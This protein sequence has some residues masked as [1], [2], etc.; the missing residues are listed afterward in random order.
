M[1]SPFA[2]SR[3][4]RAQ[5]DPIAD[6]VDM[7]LK[8][9]A[10]M[11][12]DS[13]R[14]A[15]S[16]RRRAMAA[17]LA[18]LNA[19]LK[20]RDKAEA[21]TVRGPGGQVLRPESTAAKRVLT[22]DT[23]GEQ[24]VQTSTGELEPAAQNAPL[25]RRNGRLVRERA[26]MRPVDAGVDPATR[27]RQAVEENL[28]L[29]EESAQIAQTALDQQESQAELAAQESGLDASLAKTRAAQARKANPDAYGALPED[30]D[31]LAAEERA[32]AARKAAI[33]TKRQTMG[34]KA[35]YGAFENFVKRRKAAVSQIDVSDGRLPDDYLK[36]FGATKIPDQNTPDG[37]KERLGQAKKAE[38]GTGAAVPGS[39]QVVTPAENQAQLELSEF[40]A[41]GQEIAS[42]YD[43]DDQT[44]QAKLQDLDGQIEQGNA[45]LTQGS[46]DVES[47]AAQARTAFEALLLENQQA[48]QANPDAQHLTVTVG[49]RKE[50]W[51]P[52]LYRRREKLVADAKK[53]DGDLQ[54]MQGELEAESGRLQQVVDMRNTA[55]SVLNDRV[56]KAK[57]EQAAAVKAEADR[58][59]SMPHLAE[60]ADDLE[61][62]DRDVETR[63]AKV[64]E[65]FPEGGEGARKAVLEEARVSRELLAKNI[66]ETDRAHQKKVGSAYA[67]VRDSLPGVNFNFY[68]RESQDKEKAF[69]EYKEGGKALDEQVDTAI[70]KAAQDSGVPE[71][72][73][74]KAFEREREYDWTGSPESETSRVLSTGKIAVKPELALDKKAY[75][76]AIADA[77]ATA[78][79]K[80]EAYKTMQADRMKVAAAV[81]PL[82]ASDEEGFSEK[83]AKFFGAYPVMGPLNAALIA[84]DRGFTAWQEDH[85]SDKPQAE[86][87]LEYFDTQSNGAA[88]ARHM[89][90]AIKNSLTSLSKSAAGAGA[91]VTDANWLHGLMQEASQVEK[92][93]SEYRQR[94]GVD[95]NMPKALG[96][97][98]G[99]AYGTLLQSAP[100]IVGG[101]INPAA[102]AILAGAQSG[103][104]TYADAY[105]AYK[106]Q[107]LD[108]DSARRAARAPAALSAASTGFLTALGG[109]TGAEGLSRVLNNT[110]QRN[111][112]HA[113]LRDRLKTVFKETALGTLKGASR[114]AFFEEMPD[115]MIQ[116]MIQQMSYNTNLTV[117]EYVEQAAKAAV[118]GFFMGGPFSAMTEGTESSRRNRV[119]EQPA[120][121]SLTPEQWAG[122]LESINTFAPQGMDPADVE[123]SQ[124]AAEALLYIGRGQAADLPDATL[125]T[126]G[127]Q[128]NAKGE[129]ENIKG[130]KFPQVKIEN[131]NPIIADQSTEWLKQYMPG[132][133]STLSMDEMGARR[134]FN[135]PVA[136]QAQNATQSPP[137]LTP[138]PAQQTGAQPAATPAPATS[139]STSGSGEITVPQVGDTVQHGGRARKVQSVLPAIGPG[140]AEAQVIFED[141]PGKLYGASTL[142]SGAAPAVE[143]E[144]VW[145]F[146]DPVGTTHILPKS[147]ASSPVEAAQQFTATTGLEVQP[148][149]VVRPVLTATPE[150]ART[151]TTSA[152]VRTAFRALADDA[153]AKGQK[154]AVAGAI[155]LAGSLTEKYARQYAGV[156]SNVRVSEDVP[157]A[158]AY[159]G[160]ILHINPTI[161]SGL[162]KANIRN[163]EAVVR[164][165]I[166]EEVVHHLIGQTVT[167][168]QLAK[169]WTDLPPALRTVSRNAY[170]AA[171][172]SKL[173]KE[174]G[175][176]PT[177]A[178]IDQAIAG[179]EGDDDANRGEEF[180]RQLLQKE[181][182]NEVTEL[183]RLRPSLAEQIQAV[184]LQ[185][186]EA[187]NNVLAK[188]TNTQT[189]A[190]IEAY[191]DAAIDLAEQLGVVA[192]G[193]VP[194]PAKAET[195]TKPLSVANQPNAPP[196][197]APSTVDE[198]AHQAAASPNNDLKPPTP[199]QI[200]ADNYKVGPVTISG[201]KISVE[202][203][204]GSK[205][206]PEWPALKDHYGRIPGTIAQDGELID[207]FVVPG[208][209]LDYAGPVFVVQQI[210]PKTGEND[211]VKA[212]IGAKN[213]QDARQTY[214][215]NYTPDWKGFGGFAWEGEM[216]RF[217]QFLSEHTSDNRISRENAANEKQP[218]PV[219]QPAAKNKTEGDKTPDQKIADFTKDIERIAAAVPISARPWGG[220]KVFIS[221]VYKAWAK[222][223]PG[224]SLD[225]FKQMLFEQRAS[226]NLS[227]LDL[228][229]SLTPEQKAKNAES[230]TEYFGDVVNLIRV[231]TRNAS[232]DPGNGPSRSR[233][234]FEAWYK[235]GGGDLND[236]ITTEKAWR[237]NR[238]RFV[239]KAAAA[240]VASSIRA[241]QREDIQ[242]EGPTETEWPALAQDTAPRL[243]DGMAKKLGEFWTDISSDPKAFAY[244]TSNATDIQT[245]AKVMSGGKVTAKEVENRIE[246]KHRDGGELV[247][248]DING[249]PDIGA[250]G[251][252]SAGKKDGG[253]KLMY[254]IALSWAANNG[255]R[256]N[257]SYALSP[258]NAF[259]RR[260]S[261]MLSSA[262]RYGTTRHMQVDPDQGVLGWRDWRGDQDSSGNIGRLAYREMTQ[263]LRAY[264]QLSEFRYDF[265]AGRFERNGQPATP[266]DIEAAIKQTDPAGFANAAGVG[267]TTAQRAIITQTAMNEG[268]VADESMTAPERT[269]YAP[270]DP[271][272]AEYMKAVEAGDMAK[273]Q[274]MVDEAAKAAGYNIE[275]WH[276]K[277]GEWNFTVFNTSSEAGVHFGTREQAEMRGG[278]SN[279]KK[280]FLKLESTARVR[281]KGSFKRIP[282]GRDSAVYLNRFEGIPLETVRSIPGSV[283]DRMTDSQFK[284]A[285]P[286]S[287]DSYVVKNAWQ[288]KAAD[289][290]TYDD[291]GSVVP[292]SQRF[293]PAKPDIRFAPA[294]PGDL[295][296]D[297]V[298]IE[299]LLAALESELPSDAEI[300]RLTG[301]TLS[302]MKAI[303]DATKLR[304]EDGMPPEVAETIAE[305]ERADAYKAPYRTSLKRSVVD[306]ERAQRGAAPIATP[307][308]RSF[309]EAGQRAA[310]TL[311]RDPMAGFRLVKELLNEPRATTDY[312]T[313]LL[314]LHK[315]NIRHDLA[316]ARNEVNTLEPGSEQNAAKT[317]YDHLLEDQ[318]DVDV[319][320]RAAG[321]EKG[322]G[323]NAQKMMMAEDH[324]PEA[325][326][327]TYRTQANHGAPVSP[328]DQAEVNKHAVK[329]GAAQ[330]NLDAV[331]T[332]REVL[333]VEAALQ[334]LA[335]NMAAEV[336]STVKRGGDVGSY[337]KTKAQAARARLAKLNQQQSG[338]RTLNAPAD[339]ESDVLADYGIIGAEYIANGKTSLAD[340]SAAMVGEF[341]TAVQSRIQEIYTLAQAAHEVAK[342]E[343]AAEQSRRDKLATPQGVLDAFK[344]DPS[345]GLN[346]NL[347]VNLARAYI[348]QGVNKT[349]DVITR[350]TNDLQALFPGTTESNVR[351]ILSDYGKTTQPTKDAI[352]SQLSEVKGEAR[353]LESLERASRGQNP[354][355]TG[356]QRGPMAQ[357]MRELIGQVN[358]AMRK[359]GIQTTRE[360]QLATAKQAAKTRLQNQIDDLNAVIEGRSKPRPER[361]PL[362]Y[363]AELNELVK[364]RNELKAV[365]D[366]MTGE[367]DD[368]KWNRAAQRA[369]KASEEYYRRKIASQDFTPR[370]TPARTPSAETVKAQEDAA[371][372]REEFRQLRELTGV[373]QAE[374]LAKQKTRLE[375]E[376]AKVQQRLITGERPAPNQKPL[377]PAEI[378]ALKDTLARLRQ[379]VRLVEGPNQTDTQRAQNAAKAV[380]R[381]IDDLNNRI[382]RMARGE[383]DVAKTRRA[384]VTETPELK[385]LREEKARL[386][387]IA[388][389]LVEAQNPSRLPEE[390]ALDNYR[391]AVERKQA[392]LQRKLQNKEYLEVAPKARSEVDRAFDSRRLDAMQKLEQAKRDWTTFLFQRQL[393]NRPVVIRA[394]S[395]AGEALNTSRA[396]LTSIDLSA[397]LRQG[398]FIAFGNPARAA[399]QIWPMLKAFRSEKYQLEAMEGIRNHPNYALAQQAG[400]YMTDMG[401][402]D[403]SKMEE[404]YMSRWV[405]HIRGWK[406]AVAGATLGAVAGSVGTLGIG[407][408]PGAA[409]GAALGAAGAVE[410]SQRAF[411]TF[412]NL[413]RFESFNAMVTTLGRDG[414]V[415]KAE[416]E[417]L[418]QYIN[419]A[420]GRGIIGM[421]KTL[422]GKKVPPS[423]NPILS[424]IFFSPRLAAS[425]FNLLFGQPLYGGNARTRT[426]VAKEYG[427]FSMGIGIALGLAFMAWQGQDD[428]DKEKAPFL[429][430]DPR[431]SDFLKVRFGNTRLDLFGGL[432]QATVLMSRIISGQTKKRGEIVD[433]RGPGKPFSGDSTID[434]AAKFLRSKLSP[435]IGSIVNLLQGQDFA[436]DPATLKTEAI[437]MTVP[438]SLQNIAETMKDQG[439][440][441][442]T[443]FTLLSIFGAGLQT[444]E[445][446][447]NAPKNPQALN[448]IVTAWN[449]MHPDD[450]W[451]PS[452]TKKTDYMVKRPDGTEEA[453]TP[454]E[455]DQYDKLRHDRMAEALAKYPVVNTKAPTAD[456]IERIKKMRQAAN[457]GAK[458]IVIGQHLESLK[459]S[460]TPPTIT[461]PNWREEFA[462]S[463][464]ERQNQPTP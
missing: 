251:A 264:P 43:A 234:M 250:A 142:Q 193:E 235:A 116:G 325:L 69:S 316:K 23:T 366:Q 156:F 17:R 178:E 446:S 145:S 163:A 244:P 78:E 371:A 223:N 47:R 253:G 445:S 162:V 351:V 270:A 103:G 315:V 76:R 46:A 304:V 63:L 266:A 303:E 389:A 25:F 434:V 440:P 14:V 218:T 220:E 214:E 53:M 188:V 152:K 248:K 330:A 36:Q 75:E 324:S 32:N 143:A 438:M 105:Q 289:P 40:E 121:S 460:Q 94:T 158:A 277:R 216:A 247:I 365:V 122:A 164:S 8:N 160:G 238:M 168:E 174:L 71:A 461:Q 312:E 406:G 404:M 171:Q 347:M 3:R 95:A 300:E 261:A 26:G 65:M 459:P 225:Q 310:E 87:I 79:Q 139:S 228:V 367:T 392:E 359:M 339:P 41:Y 213:A 189:R 33:D 352:E 86:Q 170:E 327:Q 297:E 456:E 16:D 132:V 97:T 12:E 98:P 157:A 305:Q 49:N 66:Q 221:D 405:Q 231:P 441:K 457:A 183:A 386:K 232:A 368:A 242:D 22:D 295:N 151:A 67:Q 237:E 393:E 421:S 125:E 388:D 119:A 373:P 207:V 425:R 127:V 74:R 263:T 385:A 383:A 212:I 144:P 311:D 436:G 107:G 45:F 252:D 150:D 39:A 201:V 85:P 48:V 464:A 181:I 117:E 306:E 130:R 426:L 355:K 343:F 111:A 100:S 4:R 245:L 345:K 348:R 80:A 172:I 224:V 131:G 240:T 83:V 409:V 196:A 198:G 7:E 59:R 322:R 407:A 400:L 176:D 123:R 77:D 276:G 321:T 82:L 104:G 358:Q 113:T 153:K 124:R 369:A 313:A 387:E 463:R 159:Q 54:A 249:R 319:A 60:Y 364:V 412:L 272:D 106:A 290:V 432:L 126:V 335:K 380:Q 110:A 192:R 81:S 433:L 362:Q 451:M 233:Q 427:K 258:I 292:L 55:A 399:R 166:R 443:I 336:K 360:N 429:E 209:P 205:R 191:R 177:Q 99:E 323:L 333:D 167:T 282:V 254:Q 208:T 411:V 109:A 210:D 363:D 402:T 1:A 73:V 186:A 283:L 337:V 120:S 35:Q 285:V 64:R 301:I 241:A 42:L 134:M 114:E 353:L 309:G 372:A 187:L 165:V 382:N 29:A 101:A 112:L 195:A 118:G 354:L 148:A 91:A 424:T 273:A 260:T 410:A 206:R 408:I 28:R 135:A 444:Y 462:R 222:E 374:R 180:L 44:L 200:E 184:L 141:E 246:L 439:V 88:F 70:W 5:S 422:E 50:L 418:A 448:D 72:E 398:G 155:K 378:Q 194:K 108:E 344:T 236:R 415:T 140:A 350:I 296:D 10:A 15:E 197:V 265:E 346:K 128:R 175:R 287:S 442:G 96:F 328:E 458:K 211:E 6:Q 416:G 428:E 34:G 38:A 275:G 154:P 133:A 384:P 202:N 262:L 102:A 185:L 293:N 320:S 56:T 138:T 376:I 308:A 417:A 396:I 449:A 21:S 217:K 394:L 395:S 450:A 115:Q 390:I 215:R 453:M 338:T 239:R 229:E 370:Q 257:P 340:F 302:E 129:L 397:P 317:R 179:T 435:A 92:L 18:E 161:M 243:P 57:T 259:T 2:A 226:R 9:A 332:Q 281:D 288:I 269:L 93:Q 349:E 190:E 420:T 51:T 267:Q 299:D 314:L 361:Q 294:D 455:M 447:R 173:R 19:E 90:E 413:L 169:L 377:P 356:Y 230:A 274:K 204:E 255:K 423:G 68:G 403:L 329:I 37:W 278:K 280:F 279:A 30:A 286:S 298:D 182:W 58:L 219:P 284:R 147:A 331:E 391:R 430:M 227:R 326:Q 52:E 62:I 452:T 419:V 401:E 13:A 307:I 357:R 149:Q 20:A 89:G 31:A 136:N 437:K 271:G 137:P 431:S 291:K 203:P 61:Q 146:T 24:F 381:S 334:R 342:R 11:A 454:A 414:R 379:S 268:M 256:I 27:D 375:Q 341:G 318:N 199:A 84:A